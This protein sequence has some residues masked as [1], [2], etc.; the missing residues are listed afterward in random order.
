MISIE[1]AKGSNRV[2]N[3]NDNVKFAVG[4]KSS[5]YLRLRNHTS[6]K[7]SVPLRL[8]R[9]TKSKEARRQMNVAFSRSLPPHLR[10]F[11]G[12]K[13]K[14]ALPYLSRGSALDL[15]IGERVRFEGR[16]CSSSTR[17]EI[18]DADLANDATDIVGDGDGTADTFS[19]GVGAVLT[20]AE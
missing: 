3:N 10:T 1:A 17:S 6:L 11:A 7:C 8:R 15:E 12:K 5:Y 18:L 19:C 4:F 9:R 2:K 13:D 20:S 16:T 14:L